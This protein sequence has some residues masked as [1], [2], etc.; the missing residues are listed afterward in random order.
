MAYGPLCLYNFNRNGS[1]ADVTDPYQK[2]ICK[3]DLCQKSTRLNPGLTNLAV[4]S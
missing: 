1:Q 4:T 2:Q 3:K